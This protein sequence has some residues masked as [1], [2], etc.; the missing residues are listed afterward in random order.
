MT[1]IVGIRCKDGVVIAADSSATFG[2]GVGVRTIEQPTEHKIEIIGEKVI[3]AGTGYVGHSQ[4]FNQVVHDM[5]HDAMDFRDKS[6]VEIAKLLSSKGLHDFGQ[7]FVQHLEYS[8]FVAY[9]AG[10]EAVL[11]E[12]PAG[13]MS[14]DR[15][16]AFQPEIKRLDDLWFASAGSGQSITDPFLAL[17]KE[18]FWKDEAPDIQGG[19]FTAMWALKHACEVN[20]GGIK[21]PIHI[22]VLSRVKGKFQARMLDDDRKSELDNMVSSATEHF[23]KFKQIITGESSEDTAPMPKP[24]P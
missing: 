22:A 19:V 3:I 8:A 7:T 16:T 12:L 20:A 17:F 15:P 5:Y 23:A 10:G 1:S 4:R 18:I 13:S 11:C 21:G 2:N 14:Q 24:Q 6:D 9:D